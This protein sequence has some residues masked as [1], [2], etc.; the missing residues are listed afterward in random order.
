MHLQAKRVAQVT[1]MFLIL[2]I[3]TPSA[4]CQ[5]LAS[6][7]AGLPVCNLD[8]FVHQ[9]GAQAEMMYGDEGTTGLPPLWGFT[10]ASRINAG[11]TGINDA[12]LTTGHGS[13]M[14]SAWG[15]DEKLAPPNGEWDM[16]GPNGGN[17]QYNNA[18]A[19]LDASDAQDQ[20][21]AQQ[22]QAASAAALAATPSIIANHTAA[23]NATN[24][25]R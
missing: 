23:Y 12:G 4:F 3:C 13:Y 11:I 21:V 18:A 9:A 24:S 6:K 17:E 2:G 16:S 22:E 1:A 25:S 8:S 14:P 5:Q 19:G 20:V 7:N 15:A 10:Q